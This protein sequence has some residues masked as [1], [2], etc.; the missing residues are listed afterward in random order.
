MRRLVF[1]INK[2]FDRTAVFINFVQLKQTTILIYRNYLPFL[3]KI[4]GKCK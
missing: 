4:V 1:C 2:L 3:V